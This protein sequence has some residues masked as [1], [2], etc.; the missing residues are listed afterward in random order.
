M[1]DAAF[2]TGPH[3]DLVER[4]EPWTYRYQPSGPDPRAAREYRLRLW[5]RCACSP[6]G[7][8][9]ELRLPVHTLHRARPPMGFIAAAALV[10]AEGAPGPAPERL[11]IIEFAL[12]DGRMRTLFDDTRE[13]G[14]ALY[15]EHGRSALSAV[16][17]S[18]EYRPG[19]SC[20]GCRYLSVCP[21]LRKAPG[22][23]GV[24]GDR[25]PRRTWSVTN[26]RSYRICPAR[27]HMRRL[28]LPTADAVER[29]PT[30]ERGRALHAYLAEQHSHRFPLPCTTEV[31]EQWVPDGF[32][33]PEGERVLGRRLL[34][35]HAVVCPLRCV[36]DG[37]DLRIEP[38]VVRYDCTADVVVL[39]TPDLLY[40]DEGSW[41]WRETKTSARDRRPSRSLF[42]RYPQ[43]ALAALLLARG[44]LGGE[45]TRSR[46]EL[47]VLGPSGAD[48]EI[49]DPFTAATRA[50][51]EQNLRDLVTEW[52]ADDVYTP[53]PGPSCVR[54]EVARWCPSAQ[55]AE[56]AA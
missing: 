38:R 34:R 45:P 25:R 8:T 10:L 22:L 42:R 7:A 46:I 47:E 27:D 44:D 11:R 49:V 28:H 3:S 23:L 39:A 56:Q 31:P 43:L 15:R 18:Q 21:A 53:S 50:D 13:A 6:D 37:T 35:A 16:L 30:A 1:Y 17:D 54:C 36:R 5:G 2:R 51:A 20:A 52:H 19:A 4:S 12:L 26:G 24:E 33:L 9:R 48:L 55:S 14:L 32:D 41:I 29:D 40:R